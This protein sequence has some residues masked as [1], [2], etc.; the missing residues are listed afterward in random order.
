[1]PFQIGVLKAPSPFG[2][3]MLF[4]Q[5]YRNTTINVARISHCNAGV[6]RESI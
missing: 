2:F 3:Q 1:M 5:N 6:R 4:Y